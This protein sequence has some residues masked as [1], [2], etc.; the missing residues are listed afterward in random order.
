L[1]PGVFIDRQGAMALSDETPTSK[2]RL[3]TLTIVFDGG[4]IGN[5]GHGYGSF[6]VFD[7]D[8]AEIEHRKLDFSDRGNRV[9]NNEAEYLSLIAALEFAKSLD[10]DPNVLTGIAVYGDSM[11]VIKQLQGLWKVKKANLQ[12][13]HRRALELIQ[14]FG[15]YML[16]WHGRINSVYHLGH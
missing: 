7:N 11:L 10:N 16:Q 5:P 12:P 13:L 14:S 4:S 3:R 2:I 6:K 15:H 1:E 9:T 8:G